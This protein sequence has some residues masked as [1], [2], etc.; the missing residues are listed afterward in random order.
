M[1]SD[2]WIDKLAAETKG[3]DEQLSKS[4]Y[5]AHSL[6]RLISA[7]AEPFSTQLTLLLCTS[8]TMASVKHVSNSVRKNSIVSA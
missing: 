8:A 2:N 6:N 3:H 7:S 5:P 4:A 1:G